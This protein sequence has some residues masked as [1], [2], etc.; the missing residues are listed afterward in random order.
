MEALTED[1]EGLA[2]ALWR[3]IPLSRSSTLVLRK[4]RRPGRRRSPGRSTADRP[5]LESG[6]GGC[7]CAASGHYLGLQIIINHKIIKS[8]SPR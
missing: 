3:L 7:T 1:A 8:S 2:A 5:A 6:A 4:H